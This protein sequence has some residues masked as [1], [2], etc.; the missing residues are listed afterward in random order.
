MTVISD[1]HI[2]DLEPLEISDEE[3]QNIYPTD[4]PAV[5]LPYQ[6]EWVQDQS[7]VA[8]EEKG[9]RIG[10]TWG[11]A[12][13]DVLLAATEKSQGGM[14]VLYLGY[15]LEM[16]REYITTCAFWAKNF[17]KAVSKI[18]SFE[19]FIFVD[20]DPK[21]TETREIKAFRIN[22]AS[23]NKIVA[24]SSAPRSLRG[25]QG[26]VVLDEAAFHDDLQAVLKS[27]M[28]FLTWGGQVR[29]ISTHN[30]E[31]NA[32]NQ[33]IEETR[34][35]KWPYSLHR[36]PFMKAVEQGLYKRICLVKGLEWTQEKEDEWVEGIYA[37][38]GDNGAEELDAIPSPL[39]GSWLNH[40]RIVSC[41]NDDIP[42]ITWLPP[43]TDFVDWDI[44]TAHRDVRDWMQANVLPLLDVLPKDKRHYLGEDFGR[45]GDLSVDWPAVRMPDYSLETPFVLQL[46]NAPFRTQEQILFYVLDRLPRMSG[47]AFDAR[48]NGQAI[49]EY[50]R[51][52]YGHELVAEVMLS[53]SWYRENMPRLK[54]SF[55][56][57]TFTIPKQEDIIDD[58]R[59]IKLR[60]GIACPPESSTKSES[61]QRHCDSAIAAALVQFAAATIE[62]PQ[63]WESPITAGSSA[64]A[65]LTRGYR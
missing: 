18:D 55:E 28:A 58:F 41:A 62:P 59:G 48:G 10:L 30:G 31:D 36:T 42:L 57:R 26:R 56:D 45:S 52:R 27:A 22:F 16:T 29:I 51:Q 60:K 6:Q 32:F 7:D 43:A 8:I 39:S 37:N 38:Y 47:A 44:E 46:R 25:R 3:I 61:G 21:T 5:L 20:Y 23:K 14:D 9:R 2:K 11:G 15:E 54:T 34:A 35:G 40:S 64:A 33:L 12:S 1:A 65:A 53:T 24:L 17:A 50:A 19:Q 49:A 63:E 13:D 4:V